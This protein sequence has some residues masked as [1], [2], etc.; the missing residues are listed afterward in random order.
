MAKALIAA[1]CFLGVVA[2]QSRAHAHE[3]AGQPSHVLSEDPDAPPSVQMQTRIGQFDVAITA[4]PAFLKPDERGMVNLHASRIDDGQ[5]Y[6]GEVTFKVR[7]DSLFSNWEQ[8]I[9]TQQT[10]DDHFSQDFVFKD[11]GH[12]IIRAEFEADGEP[13]NVN[14]PLTIGTPLSLG[15]IGA[16]GGA[17][18]IAL[19]TV[20]LVQRRRLQHVQAARH[21]G[22]A[23]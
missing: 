15:T 18:L 6:A 5:P 22:D 23:E 17:I 13:Y 1:C 7:D 19:V 10:H 8:T 12:Y 3:V 11:E 16:V 14:L 20:N 2:L 9:G 21:H 4:F